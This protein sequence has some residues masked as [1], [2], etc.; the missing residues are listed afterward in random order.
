MTELSFSNRKE[1]FLQQAN[2]HYFAIEERLF[3]SQ[4]ILTSLKAFVENTDNLN[5]EKFE[6]FSNTLLQRHQEI[7]ALEWIPR[8]P[9]KKRFSYEIR[10][11]GE[12]YS[13]FQI[14]E[15]LVNDGK[16]RLVPVI[17]RP[18]YY[19]VFMVYPLE[20][21][22]TALGFDLGSNPE[23]L[24]ALETAR[25]TGGIVMTQRITL[26]QEK[27][28]QAGVLMFL[29]IYEQ[30]DWIANDAAYVPVTRLKRR[31]QLIGFTL[32]VLRVG[33]LIEKSWLNLEDIV[34]VIVTDVASSE[35]LYD[36][37]ESSKGEPEFS[38]SQVR[39]FGQRKWL[40]T[41]VPKPGAFVSNDQIQE[42]LVLFGAL[43][44]SCV[45]GSY[46]YQLVG[47]YREV[48]AK[49]QDLIKSEQRFSL[50][51]E[52]SGVG[53]WDWFEIQGDETYW[54]PQFYD[55][56]GYR[57]K[58]IKSSHDRFISIIH[59]DD[60][61]YSVSM[62]NRHLN[63]GEVFDIELRLQTKS[64]DYKWFRARGQAGRDQLDNPVRMVGSL[65]DIH[66][67][68]S[69]ELAI[70]AYAKELKRS[71]ADLEQFAFVASHDLKA[72]LRGIFT[73][74][75]WIEGNIREYMDEETESY[76]ELLKG[77]ILRLEGLLTSLLV[78]SRIGQNQEN[79]QSIDLNVLIEDVTDLLSVKD[80][81]FEVAYDLPTI[82]ARTA[83]LNQTFQ[84]LI[85][86]AIKHHDQ[87]NGTIEIQHN[88]EDDNHVFAII[89]DGP[90][91]PIDM[92]ETVF[93]MFQTLRPRDEVE[94]SGMG[95]AIIK[96]LIDY[97]GGK[98]WIENTTH[99]VGTIVK[100]SI[101]AN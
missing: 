13:G 42:L 35:T 64:G 73:L 3:S 41:F 99:K 12:G 76:L 80:Q 19:P 87:D 90:G 21:N 51:A 34:D 100:F 65:Q 89:D 32:I 37:R 95:L 29:P 49:T 77:R 10:A 83:V 40:F 92:R 4:D 44:L 96:K 78:Y 66:S 5:R 55:L 18:D 62:M 101:P 85:G 30:E 50:A 20:G 14:T 71:N 61:E 69:S 84:N 97:H 94:G 17:H 70:Q 59:P 24:K 91:I 23:R 11:Q 15:R 45:T 81:G 56:L 79:L 25:D 26:V 67:Q 93:K 16:S 28:S 88:V 58:E 86:N 43:F 1:A 36:S 53:I 38:N 54:S 75:E 60:V 57:D 2:S 39:E 46:I 98:I 47:S 72:P 8:I 9:N 7:Q 68:K 33:D 52:G 63:E 27:E 31:E 74:A 82:N 6:R 48:K 22:E